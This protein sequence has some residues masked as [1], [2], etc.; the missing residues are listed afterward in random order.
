VEVINEGDVDTMDD[1]WDEA[2]ERLEE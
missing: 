1:A 2:V